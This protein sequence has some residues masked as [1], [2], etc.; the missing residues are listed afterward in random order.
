M[1]GKN[2]QPCDRYL[3]NSTRLSRALSVAQAELELGNV[4]LEDLILAELDGDRGT[5]VAILSRLNLSRN[6]LVGARE[7]CADLR[8]QMDEA[9][10]EDLPTLQRLNL[11]A[12]GAN[13]ATQ[14]CVAQNAW[15]R[16]AHKM[17]AQGFSGVLAYFD[18]RIDALAQKTATLI[19]QIEGLSTAVERGEVHL[20]VEENRPGNFKNAFAELYTAWASFSEEFLASSLLST[21]LWYAHNGRGSLCDREVRTIA[22]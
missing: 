18:A 15:N 12:I 1:G 7:V 10:F 21:E 3:G 4:A 16:I 8:Q 13:L 22:A 11:E 17:R 14:G 9:G 2:H 20:V 5:I 19:H 6:A